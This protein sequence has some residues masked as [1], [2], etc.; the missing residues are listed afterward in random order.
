MLD[1][2]DALMPPETSLVGE[3][4]EFVI[5]VVACNSADVRLLVIAHAGDSE[6]IRLSSVDPLQGQTTMK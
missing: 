5:C 6:K 3:E 4:S 1:T 2:G